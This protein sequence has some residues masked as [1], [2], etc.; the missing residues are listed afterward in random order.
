M[1]R[2]P[3]RNW[4]E[5]L[6]I[7][8]FGFLSVIMLYPL[9]HTVAGSFMTYGEYMGSTFILFPKDPTLEAYRQVF[10][11]GKIFSPAKVT[12]LVTVVGTIVGLFMTSLTAYALSRD[13]RGAKPVLYM[14]VATMFIYAGLIPNYIIYRGLGLIDNLLVYI[15]PS[16][17]GT[18]NLI[19]MLTYFRGFPQELLDS[20]RIDGSTEYSTYFR[21]VLPLSK[22]ILATI[23]LFIAV[24]Q[25]NLLFPSL[26]F[27]RSEE[28][29]TLQEYL[30]RIVTSMDKEHEMVSS[31]LVASETVKLANVTLCILPI[32]LLYPFLQK[33]FVDGIMIG[34]IKQ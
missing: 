10:D 13:F 4:F 25:W 18:F 17:I 12:I 31:V 21:I 23:G 28:K 2:L 15:L 19:I 20:A 7:L 29:K 16:M 6:N 22:P 32:I 34:S 30:Y 8:L 14:I 24:R 5:G 1:R 27:V 33:Y 11:S 26:F 3:N 9:V